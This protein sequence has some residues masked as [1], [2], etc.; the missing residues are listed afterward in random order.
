MK[1][2]FRIW[3]KIQY[4]LYDFRGYM[5][6]LQ[7]KSYGNNIKYF[8][9]VNIKN[10]HNL[11]VGDNVS[12][13][14]GAYINALGGIEIGNNVSISAMS[15]IVSTGLE[16]T[17]LKKIK[18]HID[19]KIIIGNNVQI[20]VGATILAG[21]QIKDNVVIGAGSVVT[22]NIESNSVIAGIPARIINKL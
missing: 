10:P 15:I 9:N 22:K 21:V 20:G 2:F 8:G 5:Y 14:D 11:S 13:N 12:F 19:K 17:S 16:P 6:K 18:K 4:A 3:R 7:F 1:I